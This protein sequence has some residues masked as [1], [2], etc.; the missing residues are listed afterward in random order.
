MSNPIFFFYFRLLQTAA[1][2]FHSFPHPPR[3][4]SS[5]PLSPGSNN[6]LAPEIKKKRLVFVRCAAKLLI[7]CGNKHRAFLAKYEAELTT[8]IRELVEGIELVNLRSKS[9]FFYFPF[10]RCMFDKKGNPA[11]LYGSNLIPCRLREGN[12]NNSGKSAKITSIIDEL[13]ALRTKKKAAEMLMLLT[14][15][16]TAFPFLSFTHSLSLFQRSLP[17]PSRLIYLTLSSNCSSC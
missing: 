15:K 8:A 7:N 10:S 9:I 5:N 2:H 14:V 13:S 11:Q 6:P 17:F 4:N 12:Q 3:P 1:G 16:R